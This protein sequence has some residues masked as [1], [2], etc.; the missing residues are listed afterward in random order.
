MSAPSPPASLPSAAF[1]GGRRR[2]LAATAGALAGGW[3]AA[4]PRPAR[5][6]GDPPPPEAPGARRHDWTF[7]AQE[8]PARLLGPD[9]PLS[10]VWSYSDAL[11][12]VLRIRQ[13]DA[14]RARLENALPEH[15]SIHWH[16]VR[17]PN[18]MDGVQYLTQPPVGPGQSFTYEFTP[19]DTGT[20]FLHPHCNEPGQVGRGLAATL[21]V[22]GD[23]P[24]PPD[25]DI[26]LACKDWRLAED[27]TWLP[28]ET[29]QGAG[30]AGTFGTVR[31]VNGQRAF[32]ATVP[33]HGDIRLRLLNLDATRT[34]LARVEGAAAQVIAIDGNAVEPF[35]LEQWRFGPAMRV[36]LRVRA[37]AA[38]AGFTLFDDF[39]REPWP[40]ARFTAAP[41]ALAERPF[42]PRPLRAARVPRADLA[43]AERLPFAFSA[44]PLGATP[45]S[46][47]GLPPDDPFA[48]LLL[49]SLCVGRNTF[50][51]INKSTWPG[52]GNRQLPPPLAELKAGRSYVF[53]LHNTTPHPH[54]IHLHGHTFEVLSLSRQALPRFLA[55]TVLLLPRERAEIAFVAA[56]GRWMFHCHVLE[57][58]ETGM[59]GWLRVT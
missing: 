9:G 28:F 8:R 59:M 33:A 45:G 52:G 42:A 38:G 47:A 41:S 21:V 32:A 10:R 15:T 22:E 5:A 35:A 49:D 13:G 12:P 50:W 30:R 57:H 26:V 24:E 17:V 51:A 56:P 34:L 40:L 58:L 11:L 53:E 23:E 4:P 44:A 16:G 19:P 7:R 3:L 6:G 20:F 54:P 55:D 48:R 39:P 46:V 27:G 36:D 37:P 43:K 1:R 31:A 29:P 18:A 14:I 25:A 2:L